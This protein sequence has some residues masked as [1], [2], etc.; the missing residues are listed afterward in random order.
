MSYKILIIDDEDELIKLEK[1]RLEKNHYDVITAS[2]GVEGIAKA[3]EF[4]PDLIV[5]DVM[6]PNLDG[7]SFVQELKRDPEIHSIPILVVSAREQLKDIFAIEGIIKDHYLVKPF[8]GE[9]LIEKVEKILK[10]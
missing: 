7:Y 8:D 2:D 9:A 1:K 3:R 6:M 5:L 4:K 10:R